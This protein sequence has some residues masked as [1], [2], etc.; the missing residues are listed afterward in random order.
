MR[1]LVFDTETSGKCNF[2]LP[3][4]NPVQPYIVQLAALLYD[5][6]QLM[7]HLN[8]ICCPMIGPD[9]VLIPKEATDV[10]GITDDVAKRMGVP[11]KMIAAM[12][13]NFLK[14]SDRIVAHNMDFDTRIM[15]GTYLRSG[16][17]VDQL[18][19]PHRVCTMKAAEPVLKLPGLYG[20]YKWPSLDEAYKTL[21]DKE[22][23]DNAHDALADAKA[24]A[25]ILWALEDAGHIR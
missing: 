24:C 11:M 12:F 2:K 10:H 22:G 16:F 15:A 5:G 3:P 14:V 8:L 21:V 20:K 13:N 7:A 23:F 18:A 17:P 1:T 6:R 19:I 9:Q 25:A 4:D